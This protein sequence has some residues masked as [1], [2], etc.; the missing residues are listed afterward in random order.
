[1]ADMPEGKELLASFP[2]LRRAAEK[3]T[4]RESFTRGVRAARGLK[5]EGDDRH[6][7]S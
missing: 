2:N 3:L 1:M 4:A 7:R 5:N 6:D